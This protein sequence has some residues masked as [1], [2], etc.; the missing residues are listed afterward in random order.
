MKTTIL[1]VFLLLPI[2]IISQ[3]VFFAIPERASTSPYN[4][5]PFGF[6]NPLNLK[7]TESFDATFLLSPSKFLIP[8]LNSVASNLNFTLSDGSNIG[9]NVAFLGTKKFQYGNFKLSAQKILLQNFNIAT[10]LNINMLSIETYGHK[11]NLSWDT[12]VEYLA[13]SNLTF[14]FAYKNLLGLNNFINSIANV[15]LQTNWF[16]D[17]TIG[18]EAKIVFKQYTSY[19][20]YVTFQPFEN[21]Y[22]DFNIQTRPPTLTSGVAYQFNDFAISLF[23]EYNNYLMFT[24]TLA[25]IVKF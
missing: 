17:Y 13:F 5:F 1:F 4:C 16:K 18:A 7:H 3:D 15:G 6:N 10:S 11:M 22:L 14:S 8:E 2:S 25:L 12:F 20:F 21:L 9:V 23:L 24:Q 19:I